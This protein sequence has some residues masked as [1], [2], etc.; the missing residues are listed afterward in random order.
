MDISNYQKHKPYIIKYR[1]NN[2]DKYNTYMRGKVNEYYYKNKYGSTKEQYRNDPIR[3]EDRIIADIFRL[4]T[5]PY[6]KRGI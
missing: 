1:N 2:K 5:R 3:Q 4:Y 6:S